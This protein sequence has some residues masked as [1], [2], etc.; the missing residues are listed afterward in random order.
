MQSVILNVSEAEMR[1]LI[2]VLTRIENLF[3]MSSLKGTIVNLA[4]LK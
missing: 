2:H 1:K 3:F 4:Q